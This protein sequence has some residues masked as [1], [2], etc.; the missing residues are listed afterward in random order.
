MK[1]FRWFA[2]YSRKKIGRFGL[3]EFALLA[4]LSVVFG[5]IWIF[6]EV[7]EEVSE[8]A[9]HLVDHAIMMSLRVDG[10][11]S[12][13]AGPEWLPEAARDITALGS[14][15]IV[16]LATVFVIGFLLLQERRAEAL[17]VI[18]TITGGGILSQVLKS[19]FQRERPD[20][21][22]HLIDVSTHSF[23][24]GH[25]ML[26]SVTYI[27]LGALLA[28]SVSHRRSKIYCLWVGVFLAV[29]VGLTRVYLGVHFPSD[30]L[31]GWAAGASWAML[32]WITALYLQRRGKL[33]GHDNSPIL[34]SREASP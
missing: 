2:E 6:V 34:G 24:S 26:S 27:T 15:S 12:I 18:V 14:D 1:N 3:R 33:H 7:A 23:P 22:F 21:A 20:H 9:A 5:G 11:P 25:S 4:A 8:G 13:P 29:L 17:L 28:R 32:C 31:A 19:V 16:I 10:V 30:V